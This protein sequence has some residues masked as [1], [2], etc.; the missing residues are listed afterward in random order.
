[1]KWCKII[2]AVLH[3]IV[4]PTVGVLIYLIITPINIPK[5]WQHSLVSI[6]FFV[7]YIVPTLMLIFLKYTRNIKSTE[8]LTIQERK[9]PVLFMI[10]LF[11]M[12]GDSFYKHVAIRD[13]SYLFYGV[14][15]GLAVIY[16]FLYYNLK[17]SLHLVSMGSAVGFFFVFQF[18]YHL[19]ILPIISVLLILSGLLS[20]SRLYLKAH[21]YKEVYIGFF[22]GFFSQFLVFFALT[23]VL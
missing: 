9:V 11:F 3:P 4:M 8:L 19:N 12:I 15:L 6:V 20:S 17:I 14:S 1:M 22:I 10:I 23:T 13:L 18:I 7:T 5:N 21:T 16:F 2:S